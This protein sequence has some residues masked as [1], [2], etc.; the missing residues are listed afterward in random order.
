MTDRLYKAMMSIGRSLCHQRPDRSF[1]ICGRQFPVCARCTGVYIGEL[2]ALLS[3]RFIKPPVMLCAAF[4][5][6]MLADWLIQF[7]KVCESTNLRRLITG[8][9]C[10][11]GVGNLAIRLLVIVL[12]Y[13]EG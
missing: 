8:L 5:A 6:V 4:C 7:F 13:L 12:K 2:A 10:G 9:L 11:Y 3:Y 1:F